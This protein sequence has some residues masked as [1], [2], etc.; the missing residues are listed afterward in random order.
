M[1]FFSLMLKIGN[2]GVNN[3]IFLVVLLIYVLNPIYTYSTQIY[4]GC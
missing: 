4:A 1:L 3:T 2:Q